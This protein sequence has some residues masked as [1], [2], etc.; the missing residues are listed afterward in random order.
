MDLSA[1]DLSALDLSDSSPLSEVILL[2]EDNDDDVFLMRRAL[3]EA[4]IRS[5]LK[6]ASHGDEAIAYLSGLGPFADRVT[7]PLPR[8][9][10]LDLKLPYKSGHEVIAW[11]RAQE[12]FAQMIVI[13]LT[14][15]QEA[16]DLKRAY[17]LGANSY[18]V[19]PPTAEQLVELAQAFKQWWLLQNRV[20]VPP[21]LP[22]EP[23]AH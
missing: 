17:Q 2:V 4:D 22:L 7:Y 16:V 23:E 5:P 13:V 11:I 10:F 19:K 18:V 15:S 8:I 14:S 6:L 21:K 3:K 1:L 9:V 12:R 20:A